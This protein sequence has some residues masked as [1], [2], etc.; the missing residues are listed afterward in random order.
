MD[1]NSKK[2]HFQVNIF[3]PKKKKT[4]NKKIDLDK[5]T[6]DKLG[7]VLERSFDS[8]KYLDVSFMP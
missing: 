6:G 5:I 8:L 4:K 1:K 2:Y 7:L 3:Y